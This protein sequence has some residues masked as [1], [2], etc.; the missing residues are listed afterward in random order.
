MDDEEQPS[1]RLGEMMD[2]KR[3][4]EGPPVV[5]VVGNHKLWQCGVC[6]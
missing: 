2:D 3:H 5:V 6:N 4:D 1:T